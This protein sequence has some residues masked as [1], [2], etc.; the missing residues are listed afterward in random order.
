M[1]S[2]RHVEKL[3]AE[4]GAKYGFNKEAFLPFHQFITSDFQALDISRFNPVRN[5]FLN[6]M[7]TEMPGLTMVISIVKMKN[8][9]RHQVYTNFSGQKNTIVIDRQ[10]ITSGFVDHVRHD[11]DL[12]VKL[13]LIFVTLTLILSFGQT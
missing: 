11:F 5:L 7:I 6:D 12:L 2:G 9:N 8:A 4:T 13:C 1:K 3:L 10:E